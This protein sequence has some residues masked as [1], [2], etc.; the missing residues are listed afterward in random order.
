M[1]GRRAANCPSNKSSPKPRERAEMLTNTRARKFF[2]VVLGI[3]AVI[4]IAVP[5]LTLVEGL[6][7]FVD[8]EVY[9][10]IRA[11]L[12]FDLGNR[13]HDGCMVLTAEVTA[14]LR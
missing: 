3:S 13:M 11:A 7:K 10:R 6:Q 12:L 9:G 5:E 2:T 8:H 14:N 1:P 4:R